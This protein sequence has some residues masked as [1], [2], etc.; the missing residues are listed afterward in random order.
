[1]TNREICERIVR[2]GNCNGISCAGW[3]VFDAVNVGF[4]C[5]LDEDCLTNFDEVKLARNWLEEHKED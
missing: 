5:P 2:N 1:M 4:P 3:D